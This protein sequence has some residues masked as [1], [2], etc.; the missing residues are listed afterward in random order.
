MFLSGSNI[1][2]IHKNR[3]PERNLGF[4]MMMQVFQEFVEVNGNNSDGF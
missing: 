4:T 3:L 1:F 2:I